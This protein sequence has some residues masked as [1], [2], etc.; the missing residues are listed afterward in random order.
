M[1]AGED[2]SLSAADLAREAGTAEDRIRRFVELGILEPTDS[3]FRPADIQRVRVAEALDRAGTPPEH[4]GEI[5]A[6]GG[7][8]VPLGRRTVRRSDAALG[9][10]DRGCRPCAGTPPSASH[11]FH[12]H[13][14]TR[15]GGAR[16]RHGHGD[17]GP[18]QPHQEGRPDEWGGS[19]HGY[20][21]LRGD[22][23]RVRADRRRGPDRRH[24]LADNARP[25]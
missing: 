6:A 25:R 20:V 1:P 17:R 19:P 14:D 7:V 10:D 8:H 22:Q 4:L 13:R 2:R 9:P 5:I 23:R 11:R 12:Q 16:H 18:H 15:P 21:H 3:I 24:V